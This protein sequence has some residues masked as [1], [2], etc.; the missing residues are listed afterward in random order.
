MSFCTNNITS[1]EDSDF[2]ELESP[3]EPKASDPVSRFSGEERVMEERP[4]ENGLDSGIFKVS[5]LD[6][7]SN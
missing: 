5:N 3:I 1:P 4:L 7:N 2:D 6:S